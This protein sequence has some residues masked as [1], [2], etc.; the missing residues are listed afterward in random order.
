MRSL[1]PQ[2]TFVSL[3]LWLA[4]S[5][6]QSDAEV[7]QLLTTLVER[8]LVT[9]SGSFRPLAELVMLR[10]P[11]SSSGALALLAALAS[12]GAAGHVAQDE[13]CSLPPLA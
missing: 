7:L 12:S 6:G 11:E 4:E 5:A 8:G 3:Q 10:Q 2:D 9:A 1:H 13:P